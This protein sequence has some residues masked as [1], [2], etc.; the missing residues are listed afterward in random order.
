MNTKKYTQI[1][2]K[3]AL[4]TMVW[5]IKEKDRRYQK[6]KKMREKLFGPLI[7]KMKLG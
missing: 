6:E 3:E 5:W 2:V 4:K 7:K 1:N